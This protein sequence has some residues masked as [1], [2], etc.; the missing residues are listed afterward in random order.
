MSDLASS[1]T[2]TMFGRWLVLLPKQ[3][4]VKQRDDNV[5]HDLWQMHLA[6]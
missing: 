4:L 2:T 3:S 1:G 6:G 5:V